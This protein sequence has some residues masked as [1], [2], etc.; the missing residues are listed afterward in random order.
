MLPLTSPIACSCSLLASLFSGGAASDCPNSCDINDDG[1]KNIADAITGLGTLFS[2]GSPLP[3][4]DSN[5]CGVDPT[6]DGLICDPTAA[7]P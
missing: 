1:S 3:D 5:D 2:G 7:C 4:P 6:A